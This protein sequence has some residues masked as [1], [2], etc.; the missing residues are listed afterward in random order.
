MGEPTH[1]RVF[2]G[3]IFLVFRIFFD[4]CITEQ[5]V[6][7]LNLQFNLNIFSPKFQH[8]MDVHRFEFDKTV[9]SCIAKQRV[10]LYANYGGISLHVVLELASMCISARGRG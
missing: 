6:A 10:P 8:H 5:V 1:V 9:K 2:R 7:W 4:I 3:V